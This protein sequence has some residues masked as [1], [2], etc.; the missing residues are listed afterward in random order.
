MLVKTVSPGQ[1]DD[2]C[3]FSS[4]QTLRRVEMPSSHPYLF[5][6]LVRT[7]QRQKVL[8]T[9]EKKGPKQF[10]AV[11]VSK[12]KITS[13]FITTNA[14]GLHEGC[15]KHQEDPESAPHKANTCEMLVASANV[16]KVAVLGFHSPIYTK[17]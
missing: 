15:H 12:Q 5:G 8:A 6:A 17:V 11:H 7:R 4:V 14:S 10:Q 1:R 2:S 16:L 9:V 13:R 3:I